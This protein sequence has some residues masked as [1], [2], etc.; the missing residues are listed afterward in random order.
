[1]DGF[2]QLHRKLVNWE[3]YTDIPVKTLFIHCLLMANFKPKKWQGKD[4]QRGQFI[5]S[6]NKLSIQTGLS[7]QQVRTA[8]KKLS[9]TN[10]I[11]KKNMGLFTSISIVNYDNYQG[12]S[13]SNITSDQP[14]SNQVATTT[15]KDNKDNKGNKESFKDECLQMCPDWFDNELWNEWINYRWQIK[16]AYK[17]PRGVNGFINKLSRLV[18]STG[19]NYRDIVNYAMDNEWHNIHGIKEDIRPQKQQKLE[20]MDNDYELKHT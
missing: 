20:L 2:I 16:K 6:R 1:M 12:R 14:S 5:T 4:I 7:E 15:N 18:S 13:T 9:S 19:D 17:T 8:L 3:W 11:T 10:D